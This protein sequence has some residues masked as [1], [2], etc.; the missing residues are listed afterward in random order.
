[1]VLIVIIQK[2]FLIGQVLSQKDNSQC[3]GISQLTDDYLNTTGI[4]SR[5]NQPREGMAIFHQNNHIII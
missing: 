3:I 5:I 1:M 2:I 4:L